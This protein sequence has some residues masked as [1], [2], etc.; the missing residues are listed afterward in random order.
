MQ[1]RYSALRLVRGKRQT[2]RWL[3]HAVLLIAHCVKCAGIAYGNAQLVTTETSS[4]LSSAVSP[5]LAAKDDARRLEEK[6]P[7]ASFGTLQLARTG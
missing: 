5:P 6:I 7:R 3:K 4:L 2:R 1:F